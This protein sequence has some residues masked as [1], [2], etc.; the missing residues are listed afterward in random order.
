V[1]TRGTSMFS[2]PTSILASSANQSTRHQDFQ[3]SAR[4]KAIS[5]HQASSQ[6]IHQVNSLPF[7]PCTPLDSIALDRSINGLS[8]PRQRPKNTRLCTLKNRGERGF[9]ILL[10]LRNHGIDDGIFCR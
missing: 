7:P 1:R 6:S 9:P 5:A 4:G 10:P 2:E 8:T 3:S